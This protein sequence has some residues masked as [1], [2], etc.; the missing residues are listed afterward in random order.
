MAITV[1][2]SPTGLILES[3]ARKIPDFDWNPYLDV[4]PVILSNG[5]Q[6]LTHVDLNLAWQDWLTTNLDDVDLMR[7]FDQALDII[8]NNNTWSL[9]NGI[10][11]TL[12]LT[13]EDYAIIAEK[14]D[15]PIE[16]SMMSFAIT[17]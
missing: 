11:G 8:M 15:I 6:F 13:D 14:I 2:I 10:S 16:T 4:T 12:E 7:R 5:D 9:T 17:S 1:S 3:E